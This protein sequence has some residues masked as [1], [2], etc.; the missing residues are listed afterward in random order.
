MTNPL[1]PVA[2]TADHRDRVVQQL[3]AAFANDRLS[4]EQLDERLAAVNRAQTLAELESLLVDPADPGR[5]LAMD[6]MASRLAPAH[7]VPARGVV[8][9]VMGGFER[10]GEW[11]VPRQ[12]KVVAVLGGGALDLRDARLSPGVTELEVFSVM[13][14]VE[15]MVPP[16]VRVECVGMAVMGGYSI[17]GGDTTEAP[18][19]PVLR[20]SGFCLM[21]GVDVNRKL[22]KQRSERR[23][24]QALE[25]AEQVRAVTGAHPN[26]S[27]GQGAHPA[28]RP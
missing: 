15:I 8:M 3:S 22:R 2:V 7:I 10:K 27:T 4:V 23:Y 20:I 21:A 26:D 6:G 25:R 5:V 14:G 18:D 17:S 11:V 16:G 1:P 28:Y 9:A 13:G 12:L 19:A 24:S